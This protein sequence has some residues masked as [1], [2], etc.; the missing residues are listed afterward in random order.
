MTYYR[1]KS[2]KRARLLRG[3]VGKYQQ[4]GFASLTQRELSRWP[5]LPHLHQELAANKHMR[6]TVRQCH[7]LGAF[8]RTAVKGSRE[9]FEKRRK[10]ENGRERIKSYLS[11]LNRHRPAY[12]VTRR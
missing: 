8:Y 4:M 7:R 3:P 10:A 12:K 11:R 5:I 1:N 2:R 9:W 6:L